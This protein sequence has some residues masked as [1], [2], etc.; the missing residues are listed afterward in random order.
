MGLLFNSRGLKMSFFNIF[1]KN[2]NSEDIINKSQEDAKIIANYLKCPYEFIEGGKQPSEIMERYLALR[3][4]GMENGFTPII[5]PLEEYID[6]NMMFEND[7]VEEFYNKITS[8]EPIDAEQWFVETAE[9]DKEFYSVN[10][11][12]EKI[13]E[14]IKEKGIPES[15]Y[16]IG[17]INYRKKYTYPVMIVKIPEKEPWKVFAYIPFGGWNDCPT[18]EEIM[19]ISK[20]WFEKYGAVPAVISSD[21][22]EFFAQPI[23]NPEEAHKLANEMFVFCTDIVFQGVE[24]VGILEEM[25]KTSTTWYFWW[26]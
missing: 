25:I 21:T 13:A 9:S 8:A 23:E 12:P 16:F 14:L 7:N 3:K 26:D 18:N 19:Y 6:R 4:E 15:H 11:N 24:Y 2:D 20:Y 1:G 5:I 10:E 17:F 22:L